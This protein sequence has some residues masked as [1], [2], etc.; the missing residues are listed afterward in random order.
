MRKLVRKYALYI[1]ERERGS[2][3]NLYLVVEKVASMNKF[4]K[5]IKI[6]GYENIDA[7]ELLSVLCFLAILCRY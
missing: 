4:N 7:A 3:K 6:G 1:M 2:I 5:S